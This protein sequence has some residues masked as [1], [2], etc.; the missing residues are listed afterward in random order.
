MYETIDGH[1]N[2]IRFCFFG[3]YCIY[4]YFH[5]T[6]K[7]IFPFFQSEGVGENGTESPNK[8]ELL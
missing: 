6:Y 5:C 2:R 4:G 7:N 1:S 8:A 3:I